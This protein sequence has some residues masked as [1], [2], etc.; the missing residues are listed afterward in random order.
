MARRSTAGKQELA[1]S[2]IVI[3][4]APHDIP[5]LWNLLPLVDEQRSRPPQQQT[6]VGL[7]CLEVGLCIEPQK[8]VDSLLGC[9]RL[10]DRLWAVDR[11]RGYLSEE[12]IQFI[13]DDA[14]RVSHGAIIQLA[15]SESAK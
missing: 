10:P 2:R 9:C 14:S 11:D 8:A 1:A 15:D 7:H 5:N 12:F 3:Y 4:S 13:V 6:G